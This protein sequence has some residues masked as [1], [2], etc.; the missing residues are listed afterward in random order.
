MYIYPT[1]KAEA[2]HHYFRSAGRQ[3]CRVDGTT[4]DLDV[5]AAK[6]ADAVDTNAESFWDPHID[7]AEYP[8]RLDCRDVFFE[9]GAAKIYI[10]ATENSHCGV[11]SGDGNA[12]HSAAA[13]DAEGKP[14]CAVYRW[15][16][17]G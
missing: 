8:D 10:G 13:K 15:F 3:V 17:L 2:V 7:A 16:Y 6:E 12:A 11:M 5:V 14:L 4:F 9:G 1:E